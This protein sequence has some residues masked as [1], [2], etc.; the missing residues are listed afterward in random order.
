MDGVGFASSTARVTTMYLKPKLACCRYP[1]FWSTQLTAVTAYNCKS[2]ISDLP[3][4][5]SLKHTYITMNHTRAATF[6]P[7]NTVKPVPDAAV[8]LTTIHPTKE[9]DGNHLWH[10][11]HCINLQN[12]W[13]LTASCSSLC[14]AG[15]F[16]IDDSITA[17][18]IWR[19]QHEISHGIA[20]K[21]RHFQQR[22]SL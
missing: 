19:S 3:Q 16:V 2:T 17:A 11:I 20:T 9:K 22:I 13:S 1:C 15:N 18:S 5:D 4:F 10:I 12:T 21:L 7:N 14:L 6:G 8:T